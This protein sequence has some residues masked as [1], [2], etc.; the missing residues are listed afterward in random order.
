MELSI[1]NISE[2]EIVF[3]VYK[4]RNVISGIVVMGQSEEI[5]LRCLCVDPAR[6]T[7]SRE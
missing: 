3:S 7:K 6:Q 4:K 5:C 2:N 1:S